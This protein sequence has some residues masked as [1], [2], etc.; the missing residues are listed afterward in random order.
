MRP[1]DARSATIDGVP[2]RWYEHGAGIPLVLVHGIPTS[3]LLWRHVVP[4]LRGAKVYAWEMTGYGGSIPAGEGRDLSMRRQAEHLLS[5]MDDQGLDQAILGGHDLGGGVIHIAATQRPTSCLGLFLTNSIGYD[6]WP[7]PSINMMKRTLGLMRRL[8]ASATEQVLRMFIHRA[9]D[10]K[11]RAKEAFDLHIQPY[12]EHDATAAF[13][14]QIDA[15]RTEDTLAVQEDLSRLDVSARIVWGAADQFQKVHYG[16]R[17][18]RDL[19]APLTRIERGRH[20][21]PEDHPE[22]VA[23]GLNELIE[24]VQR[25]THGQLT[26]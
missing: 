25:K 23:E 10:D 24:E 8:P 17:F 2:T 11:D 1:T 7:I 16:E 21:T 3:P 15:L 18:A 26:H 5:W 20:F 13:A 9:H 6:S 19:D 22:A 14:R 12:R 4:R